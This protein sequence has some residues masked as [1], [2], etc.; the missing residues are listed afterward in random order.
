MASE[1]P[2]TTVARVLKVLSDATY[3][4]ALPNG[5]EVVGHLARSLRGESA[6]RF[7]IEDCVRVEMTPYDFSK[8]RIVALAE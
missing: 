6:I 8:A 3:L 4:I 5:K 2:I 1:I 7:A